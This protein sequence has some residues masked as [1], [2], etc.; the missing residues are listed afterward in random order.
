MCLIMNHPKRARITQPNFV[1]RNAYGGLVIRLQNTFSIIWKTGSA[2][3][4]AA[5]VLRSASTAIHSA[6]RQT[7]RRASD[8]HRVP[9][10]SVLRRT[11]LT[12]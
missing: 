5:A 12:E 1:K 11:Q 8:P 10:P 4:R 6:L 7:S 3:M 2:S 9:R